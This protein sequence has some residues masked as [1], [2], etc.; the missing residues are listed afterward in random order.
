MSDYPS[1]TQTLPSPVP[2]PKFINDPVLGP[3]EGSRFPRVA[4]YGGKAQRDSSARMLGNPSQ[5]MNRGQRKILHRSR[6]LRIT[7]PVAESINPAVKFARK[8]LGLTLT[9]VLRREHQ[10][11][12]RASTAMHVAKKLSADSPF[13]RA[14]EHQQLFHLGRFKQ[15]RA[16]VQARELAAQGKLAEENV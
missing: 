1:N 11:A 4:V 12:R 14:I 16:E 3:L 6:D 15:S 9:Q 10:Y 2:V 8:L 7:I 5:K 13:R